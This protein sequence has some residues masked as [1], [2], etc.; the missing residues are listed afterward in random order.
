VAEEETEAEKLRASNRYYRRKNRDA[1]GGL[2]E[3]CKENRALRAEVQ[4]LS[5]TPSL[6]DVSEWL[7]ERFGPDRDLLA[8]VAKLYEEVEELDEA[9]DEVLS[10]FARDRERLEWEANLRDETADVVIVC[11]AIAV[12]RGFDLQ[13]AIASKWARRKRGAYAAPDTGQLDPERER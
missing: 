2:N 5:S 1:W 7:C 4:R 13:D 6:H 9:V 12:T 11:M 3:C 8:Q 10:P